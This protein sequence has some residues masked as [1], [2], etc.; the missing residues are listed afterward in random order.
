MKP[1][2][3]KALKPKN[4]ERHPTEQMRRESEKANDQKCNS[5]YRKA[6]TRAGLRASSLETE[7]EGMPAEASIS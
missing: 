4:P 5:V 1:V 2:H 3:T 6:L 7:A